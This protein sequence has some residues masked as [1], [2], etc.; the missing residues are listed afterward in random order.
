M[1]KSTKARYG[2]HIARLVADLRDLLEVHHFRPYLRDIDD[3]LRPTAKILTFHRS[4]FHTDITILNKSAN[5]VTEI[6]IYHAATSE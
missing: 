1:E 4:I 2:Y 6:L 5:N 3:P